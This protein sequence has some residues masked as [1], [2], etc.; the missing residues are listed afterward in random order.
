MR[1]PQGPGAREI[2]GGWL[3]IIAAVVGIYQAAVTRVTVPLLWPL[4]ATLLVLAG[5]VLA[6]QRARVRYRAERE[7]EAQRP[8]PVVR[9]AVQSILNGPR[10]GNR[11]GDAERDIV[12]NAL[13]THFAAGRIDQ[14][15]LDERLTTTLN[16]RT[17]EDLADAVTDL[18]SEVTG[19]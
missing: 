10:S 8:H 6:I 12:A 18:P 15:E 4:A 9:P 13:R 16:A 7:L 14:A 17:L 3:V 11:I 19:R 2:V 1:R 5:A